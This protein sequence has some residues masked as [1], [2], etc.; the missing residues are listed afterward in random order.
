MSRVQAEAAQLRQAEIAGARSIR[1]RNPHQQR[2]VEQQQQRAAEQQQRRVAEQLRQQALQRENHESR[3]LQQWAEGVLHMVYM[4][5]VREAPDEVAQLATPDVLA[6]WMAGIDWATLQR[7]GQTVSMHAAP[8]AARTAAAN[9]SQL[10]PPFSPVKCEWM[11]SSAVDAS[12]AGMPWWV[13]MW[14]A[15]GCSAQTPAQQ[16][17]QQGQNNKNTRKRNAK[18]RQKGEQQPQEAAPS[19]PSTLMPEPPP[20]WQ[21]PWIERWKLMDAWLCEMRMSWAG[22]YA[23]MLSRSEQIRTQ[24]AA[25]HDSSKEAVL[26]KARVIGCTTTGLA[27]QKLLLEGAVKPGV[28]LVEEAAE[29][30]ESHVLT[31][32]STGTQHLVMIGDHKQLKPKVE[33]Y[34]L[35]VQSGMGHNL[36]ISLFE[37]LVNQ[38]FPYATLSVQHR[39]HPC[40]SSM[41]RP[42]Y[43]DLTDHATTHGRKPLLGISGQQHVVFIDHRQPEEQ[44]LAQSLESEQPM[45]KSNKYEALMVVAIAKYLMQQGYAAHDLVLLTT[46]LGQLLEIQ[47]ALA[48][49]NLQVQFSDRDAQQLLEAGGE[50]A[51]AQGNLGGAGLRVATVDNFQERKKEKIHY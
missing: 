18:A 27:G 51:S 46:Y 40:I 25:L 44:E 42:T 43:P 38:G 41:I 9:G 17:Q 29:L 45:S 12:A 39:M 19:P 14:V 7:G 5:L 15:T 3:A 37:R 36:N 16:Q 32:L 31:S 13:K 8:F 21:L 1:A 30:L 47:Q 23:N 4:H 35:S 2:V 50:Q 6:W 28:V 10:G 22:D 49:E 26:K 20:L 24:L 48:K 34:P 33:H 11:G